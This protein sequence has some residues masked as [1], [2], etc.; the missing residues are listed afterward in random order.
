VKKLCLAL[1]LVLVAVTGVLVVGT[2]LLLRG[3]IRYANFQ[4]AIQNATCNRPVNT[5]AGP[6]S[7]LNPGLKID[8]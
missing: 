8:W 1:A 3:G 6:R 4:G 7:W 2:V 5:W